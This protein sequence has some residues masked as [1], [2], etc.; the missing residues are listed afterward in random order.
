MTNRHK[1][2]YSFDNTR[3]TTIRGNYSTGGLRTSPEASWLLPLYPAWLAQVKYTAPLTNRLLLEAGYAYQRGDFRVL[4]QPAN[5]LTNIAKIDQVRGFLEENHNLNYSNTEKKKEVK[6]S[7][8][9]VTGSHTLKVGFEDRWATA[10]QSNPYNA[11]ILRR[12][13]LSGVPLD[14]LV[15]NGPSRN[16]QEIN[17]DGGA[18]VQDQ[19]RLGRFTVNVGVRF[20]HFE[21]GVP[22]QVNPA[23]FFTPEVRMTAPIE[24]TPNWTDWATRTGFA[25]DVFGNGKTA[26]KAFAGRFVAGH[27]LSRTSQFNPIFSQTDKS[28]LDRPERRRHGRLI[29]Q[30]CRDASVQ[31]D[32]PAGQRAIRHAGR[33]RQDG[34][35]S[36][37]RQELDLRGDRR[38]RAVPP[39]PGGRRVLS[40]TVLRLCVHGQPGDVARR[41]GGASWQ[42]LDA[43][44]LHRAERFP[45]RERRRR[46]HHP[47]QPRSRQARAARGLAD[48]L[49]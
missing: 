22:A 20:D 25:W 5:P 28:L 10:L 30:R 37:A 2:R 19:W 6:A 26:V 47:L 7:L 27:A 44:H 39:R 48:Q 35:G 24:N 38:S 34:S 1:L 29:G 42:R 15:T 32:R 43:V 41:S 17:F 3:S 31:R 16:L 9:Y 14:V 11:D 36:Q 46:G 49:A 23:S 45:A 18:F 40:P 13:T 12:R 21:A 4:F 33:P 8:S